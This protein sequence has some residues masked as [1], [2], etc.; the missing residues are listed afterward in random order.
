MKGRIIWRGTRGGGEEEKGEGN[1][2]LNLA[3]NGI[4]ANGLKGVRRTK[5]K[6]MKKGEKNRQGGSRCSV[7]K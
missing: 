7:G 2:N 6:Y 3:G 5:K 4:K 1:K